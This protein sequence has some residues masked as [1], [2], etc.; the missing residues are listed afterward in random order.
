MRLA[1]SLNRTEGDNVV[2]AYKRMT[3]HTLAQ[4]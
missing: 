4:P 2:E 3:R 1:I